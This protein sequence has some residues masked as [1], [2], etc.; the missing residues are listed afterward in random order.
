MILKYVLK[1]KNK[2]LIGGNKRTVYIFWEGK[3]YKLIQVLRK[4][5]Y[6]HSNNNQNYTIKLLNRSNIENYID[7]PKDIE[8]DKL[9]VQHQAD[10]IRIAV[11]YKY[12]GIWLDSDI[13]VLNNLNDLFKYL[14]ENDGFFI[15]E[16]KILY[17][18]DKWIYNGIFGSKANTPLLK[19]CLH[20]MTNILTTKKQNIAWVEI[21]NLLLSEIYKNTSLFDNYKIINGPDSM[22]P[23]DWQNNK[24]ELL[25]NDYSTFVNIERDFQPCLI[26]TGDVYKNM[27]DYTYDQIIKDKKNPLN[28][29]VQK[30]IENSGQSFSLDMEGGGDKVDYN[31]VEIGTSNF[32]TLLEKADDTTKGIS[33]EPLKEYLDDLPNKKQIIKSNYAISDVNSDTTMQLYYIPQK[34]IKEKQLH[35]WLKGCNS[36]NKYHA[37]HKGLEEYVK[38][39][40]VPVISMEKLYKIYNIG[41]INYLKIDTEGNDPHILKSLY[42]FL[43]K[44]KYRLLSKKNKI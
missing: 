10:Y 18:Y 30:S 31:F 13:I 3:E 40:D 2:N 28:Y 8:F 5:M 6:L 26:L 1:K 17:N 9:Q 38:I 43:K 11:I 22:Y 44:K 33:V 36:V 34:I 23:S 20:K 15:T 7:I 4:L 25:E 37:Y 42:N 39:I 14:E 27:E 24:K 29:F 41:S 12:G 21:G 35:S 32:D 19:E 16:Q